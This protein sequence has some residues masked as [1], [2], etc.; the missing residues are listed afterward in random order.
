MDKW[1]VNIGELM[2][3]R[4]SMNDDNDDNIIEQVGR[5]LD[6]SLEQQES[7]V[8]RLLYGLDDGIPCSSEA[9]STILGMTGPAVEETHALALRKLRHPTD[10]RK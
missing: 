10:W 3:R 6:V 1:I 4:T 7:S 8:I 2:G 9:V 5:I